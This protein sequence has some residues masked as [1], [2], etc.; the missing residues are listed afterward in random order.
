MV[1]RRTFLEFCIMTFALFPFTGCIADERITDVS[2]FLSETE[3]LS[4]G[5]S[6]SKQNYTSLDD[7]TILINGWVLKVGEA[8]I[9]KSKYI[10]HAH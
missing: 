6:Y 3:I 4:V 10:E 9:C 8:E 5:Q 1:S 7:T 2:W